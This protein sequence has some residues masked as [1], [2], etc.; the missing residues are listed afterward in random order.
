M[1]RADKGIVRIDVNDIVG[2]R[3]GE[4]DVI[5]HECS[6]YDHTR[7]GDRLRHLYMCRCVCGATVNVIRHSLI[8]NNTRSCGCL[9]RGRHKYAN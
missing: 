4:L 9:K 8:N 6:W 3:F 5:K 7:G 1:T 2:R